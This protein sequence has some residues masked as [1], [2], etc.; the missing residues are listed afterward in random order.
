MPGPLWGP[1]PGE[2]DSGLFHGKSKRMMG[3]SKKKGVD[4]ETDLNKGRE[5][6]GWQN[7]IVRCVL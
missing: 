5:K 2:E 4:F 7:N 6:S 1:E 3:N